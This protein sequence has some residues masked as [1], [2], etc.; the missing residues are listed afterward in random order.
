M[1]HNSEARL[2]PITLVTVSFMPVLCRTLFI[3][4]HE[5]RFKASGVRVREVSLCVL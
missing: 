4:R 1:R 5:A 2:Y 3:V